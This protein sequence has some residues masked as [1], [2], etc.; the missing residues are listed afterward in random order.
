MV[1]HVHS[2][3]SYLSVN[4]S[5][6]RAGGY[7]F[8][9]SNDSEPNK[10]TKNG[11]IH[12][13]CKIL[14]N[15]MASAAETE[16]ASAFENAKEAIPMRNALAFLDHPQPPTPLQVDNTTAVNFANNEL[17]QK[18]SKAIDMRFYWL[19]DRSAQGQFKIYWKRGLH[20]Y[21]DYFTKHFSTAIHIAKRSTYLHEP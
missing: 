1:L 4:K 7:Y 14:Q 3:G 18:R 5:R 15:V 2:D 16:I 20:N 12:V 21:A 10:A 9:S 19:Q 17:K 8:L 11:A 6:S 13:L